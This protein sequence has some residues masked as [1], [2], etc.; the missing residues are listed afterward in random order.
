MHRPSVY[1]YKIDYV[2]YYWWKTVEKF[3]LCTPP[4]SKILVRIALARLS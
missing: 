4:L 1:A 2:N 3:D